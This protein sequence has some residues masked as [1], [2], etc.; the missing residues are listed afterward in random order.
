[1]LGWWGDGRPAIAKE[2]AKVAELEWV[3]SPFNIVTWLL[4]LQDEHGYAGKKVA[5]FLRGCEYRT[6]VMLEK[7][8]VLKCDVVVVSGDCPQKPG[9]PECCRDC[10]LPVPTVV[11]IWTEGERQQ[12]PPEE[13]LLARRLETLES[14][15]LP[16]LSD[17]GEWFLEAAQACIGCQACRAFCPLCYCKYC[18]VYNLS[19][20]IM[21]ASLDTVAKAQ[22]L[23]MKAYH[24]AGRCVDCGTCNI[25]CP[26]GVDLRRLLLPQERYILKNYGIL[27]GIDGKKPFFREAK[28]FEHDE[29][30]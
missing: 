18:S 12:T 14:R 28:L 16:S 29:F 8:G 21:N 6:L 9:E 1:M 2:A 7:E 27:P 19:P 15:L 23:L 17:R 26:A 11:H 13:E 4:K 30:L 22:Y 3:A 5:V 20:E 10:V 25:V 24:M